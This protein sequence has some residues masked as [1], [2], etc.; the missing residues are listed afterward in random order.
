MLGFTFVSH[1]NMVI[2]YMWFCQWCFLVVFSLLL[3]WTVTDALGQV[4]PHSL[5]SLPLKNV[6]AY[7]KE[8]KT[9][10]PNLLVD[11]RK[12]KNTNTYCS[13]EWPTFGVGWPP[14][15]MFHLPTVLA[16]EDRVFQ[17]TQGH[18]E[19]LPYIVVWKDLVANP[20]PWMRS[21]LLPLTNATL[22]LG[23]MSVLM[24]EQKTGSLQVSKAPLSHFIGQFARRGHFPTALHS[25]TSSG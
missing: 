11:T 9:R 4:N 22:P 24:A 3:Y 1:H 12:N 13:L 10:A 21:F 20:P 14:E 16:V 6:L 7:F 15:G 18:P 23:T 2:S 17:K 19:Q 25:G 8:V 5:P